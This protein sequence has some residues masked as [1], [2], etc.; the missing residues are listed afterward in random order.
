MPL[1]FFATVTEQ[2]REANNYVH[3]LHNARLLWRDVRSRRIS[4]T[5]LFGHAER[6]QV[7]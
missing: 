1:A 3:T 5:D 2:Y 6:T 4:S 7:V